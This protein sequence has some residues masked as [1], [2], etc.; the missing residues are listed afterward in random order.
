MTRP[1]IYN[2]FKKEWLRQICRE[3]KLLPYGT[4]KELCN[5]L[6]IDDEI[7]SA[8]YWQTISNLTSATTEEEI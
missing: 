4:R 8:R 7:S 5:R 3:R 1:N 2:N 6:T